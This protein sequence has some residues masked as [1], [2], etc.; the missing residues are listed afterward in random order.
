NAE[1]LRRW[2]WEDIQAQ[3]FKLNVKSLSINQYQVAGAVFVNE[4]KNILITYLAASLAVSGEITIGSMLA[5][6]YIIGQLNGPVEQLI[7]FSQNAQDAKISIDRLNEI[8][9]FPEEEPANNEFV[10]SLPSMK[11][12]NFSNLTFSFLGAGNEPVLRDINLEIPEGKVTAI[13]GASGSGKTTLLKLL[14]KYYD[15]YRGEIRIGETNLKWLSPRLWR[16][17]C[18]CVMQDGYIFSDSIAKNIAVNEQYPDHKKLIHACSV[19]N[20]LNFVESLPLGFNTKIGAEGKGIS[21]GQ[22][23]RILIA[24]AVYKN[25]SFLF[26]DEATNSLDSTNESLIMDN[27]NRFFKGKTVVVVAHRLSTI[28]NADRIIVIDN[29]Y[30]IENG[31]HSELISTPSRYSQL[32]SSQLE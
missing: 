2:E 9:S 15:N 22:R 20:I 28:R 24:R 4:G 7:A 25:P 12:I 30:V 19:A 13:V 32:V 11:H 5:I 17:A 3:F 23:Q 26:F 1:R 6:Q 10:N 29:G 14:L 18:G 8:Q 31:T 27:L 21:A 16:Q